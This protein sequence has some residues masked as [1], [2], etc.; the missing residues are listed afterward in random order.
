MQHG[1]RYGRRLYA[2]VRKQEAGLR[3]A[4]AVSQTNRNQRGQDGGILRDAAAIAQ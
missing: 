2:G 4:H 1:H 3:P